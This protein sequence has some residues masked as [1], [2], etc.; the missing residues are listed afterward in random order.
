MNRRS[1]ALAASLLAGC[2]SAESLPRAGAD[3]HAPPPAADAAITAPGPGA[4]AAI[5]APD[6]AGAIADAAGAD[7]DRCAPRVRGAYRRPLDLLLL[8]DASGSMAEPV[9]GGSTRWRVLAQGVDEFVR[10]P[11]LAGIGAG[12]QLVPQPG[13]GSACASAADCGFLFNPPAGACVAG[14][15]TQAVP[16]TFAC[17]AQR[18]ET[19]QVP[20]GDLLPVLVDPPPDSTARQI[21]RALDQRQPGGPTTLGTAVQGALAHLGAHLAARPARRAALALIT[22]GLTSSCSD[23]SSDLLAIIARLKRA[24]AGP[25]P[26]PTFVLGLPESTNQ[27]GR[28]A[29]EQLA[30]A[31]GTGQ[32]VLL[33]GA[34]NFSGPLT[35]GLRSVR[36]QALGCVFELGAPAGPVDPSGARLRWTGPTGAE[37]IA[38]VTDAQR[39]D[40]ATGGWYLSGPSQLVVCPASCRRFAP[41]AEPALALEACDG[42]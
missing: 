27:A 22:D 37:E 8:V 30:K 6:G 15:C 39:C 20:I 17:Q 33:D 18:Y 4:D 36:E 3:P 2:G 38:A 28:V 40:A 11:R 42:Q 13:V 24:A 23:S 19:L 41:E 25:P 1:L 9:A 14:A 29:L 32:P 16:E 10:D 35:D 26:I 21:S 31:G 5:T 7:A 12:L 34:T